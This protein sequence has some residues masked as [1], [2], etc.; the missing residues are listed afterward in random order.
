MTRVLCPPDGG[1]EQPAGPANV[2]S[3]DDFVPDERLD[4]SFLEDG[5]G[6]RGKAPPPAQSNVL[7]SDR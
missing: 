1:A 3:V 5:G 2:R 7:D 6:S 4:R